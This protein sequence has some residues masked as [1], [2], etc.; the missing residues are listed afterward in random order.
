ME[1]ITLRF[2]LFLT[3]IFRVRLTDV[4]IRVLISGTAATLLNMQIA[5]TMNAS[6]IIPIHLCSLSNLNNI[7]RQSFNETYER[8]Y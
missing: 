4:F 6:K 8:T 7:Q 3:T 2:T 5:S 1:Q